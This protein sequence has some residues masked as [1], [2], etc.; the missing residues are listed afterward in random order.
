MFAVLGKFVTRNR[1]VVLAA[2]IVG[3]VLVA[4]FAPPISSTSDQ[5]S[6]LPGHYESVRASNME[7]K[8]FGAVNAPG[9]ILVFN[10]TDGKKLTAA[11]SAEVTS[12]V[13]A[14]NGTLD[15]KIFAGA[16]AQP[17][18]P[19]G[20][21]QLGVVA[22]KPGLRGFEPQAVEAAK[23]M[24]TD[25][26]P[27]VAGTGLKV[28]TTGAAP[29]QADNE[30]ASA[31]AMLLVGVGTVVLILGLLALIF[32]SVLICV[33]PLIV[34][35][36]VTLVATGM[37]GWAN[38]WFDLKA[39]SSIEQILA[40]VIG[41]IGT[42]YMLFL[43]FRHR[44]R[45]RTG[46]DV[47]GATI[48]AMERAGEAIASAGGAV[49]VAFLALILSSLSIFRAIGPAMAIAVAVTLLAALTLVPALFV[50]FGRAMFWPAKN[51]NREPEAA[52]F[53][54]V[55]RNLARRPAFFAAGAGLLLAVLA[56]FSLGFT[57][58]FDFTSGL[59]S[60]A[61]STQA[62]KTLRASLPPG[63]TDPTKIVLHADQGTLTRSEV[64]DYQKALSGA[65]G[66]AQVLP[67][68][69][70][71]DSTTAVYTVYLSSDPMADAAISTVKGPLR[72]AAH[73]AAPANATALVGGTTSVFVDMDKAMAR[74][75]KV[76]FSIAG[77]VIL[78][79][80]ALLLRSL[81]APWYLMASVGLGFAATL[82]ASVIVI[83]HLK[84]DP[85]LIFI[86]PIYIYLFV[87]A[88]GTDYN[89][90]MIARLREEA[91][92]GR[93]P[94]DAAA[95]AVKH[96]GPTIAA[97]GVILSG[98]F[99]TLML[100]GNGLL[101]SLGFALSFGIAMAAF[102]MSMFL[103]PSLTALIGHAAWWPG[104]GDEAPEPELSAID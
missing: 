91:R 36:L 66:V 30:D 80:L 76:V 99:G 69:V 61:E 48:H 26:K 43:L 74:D 28:Q 23:Q 52:H 78:L 14:L 57:P 70:S 95:E 22:L 3:A 37:I 56:S 6:F 20:K 82:G 90:L 27:L 77:G 33:L 10:R 89:I 21:V 72:T 53:A 2:W 88:L 44:E 59:P 93:T 18:S 16:A 98:T 32:R 47:R 75:Y 19:N 25:L 51:W 11:D 35:G 103:T 73:E 104:H 8:Y 4:V 9:A 45:L 50:I 79:I 41:G 15:E 68:E 49:I 81:V 71:Q 84:G 55:G 62:L 63:V 100:G 85:G 1:W 102:V 7:E 60:Q 86:L 96:A 13:Q 39:D 94:R 46:D 67:G 42:D 17:P 83:Q 65:E 64:A 38:E 12:I 97:A 31:K 5:A 29:Q 34:L 24:R 40:V 101:I 54:S 58:T 87:V 92:A